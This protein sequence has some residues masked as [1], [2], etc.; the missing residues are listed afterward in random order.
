MPFG[1]DH[2]TGLI[3]LG[4]EH[5]SCRWRVSLELSPLPS[6]IR[7]MLQLPQCASPYETELHALG[8][9]LYTIATTAHELIPIRASLNSNHC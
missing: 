4:K 1:I 9:A 8:M 2:I 5:E 3:D 7:Q 6:P